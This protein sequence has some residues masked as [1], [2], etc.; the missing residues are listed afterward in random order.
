M[1]LRAC[2]AVHSPVGCRVTPRMR[3]PGGVLY[4]GQD[5]GL[6]AAGR[7]AVKKSLAM[8]VSAW[9]RRNCDQASPDR[10]GAGPVPAFFTIPM[11]STPLPSLPAG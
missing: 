5:I 2:W 7:P 1:R 10:R 6:G 4:H 8:I 3:T 11:P 9:E